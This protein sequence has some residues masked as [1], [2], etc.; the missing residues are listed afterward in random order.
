[1]VVA[2]LCCSL[3]LDFGEAV[4]RVARKRPYM[5]ILPDLILGVDALCHDEDEERG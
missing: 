4:E 3:G 5:S 1:M 2:Y